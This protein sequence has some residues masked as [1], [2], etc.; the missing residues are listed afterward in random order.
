MGK[1]IQTVSM[2]VSDTSR[3][4]SGGEA[5]TLI[6]APTVALMQWKSEI[7]LY[8]NN[9]LSILIYHGANRETSLK[10]LKDYDI[11]LTTYN[12]LESV[13][14]KQQ[15]GFRRRQLAGMVWSRMAW[16]CMACAKAN[17]GLHHL[18]TSVALHDDSRHLQP[19][20]PSTCRRSRS[21]DNTL[22]ALCMAV[23]THW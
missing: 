10:K 2:L 1:T 21:L 19:E 22:C 16:P 8:T 3:D 13:W 6:V 12:L 7:S 5:G 14:R 4:K 18:S 23:G 17:A 20:T 11:V 15:S 9:A